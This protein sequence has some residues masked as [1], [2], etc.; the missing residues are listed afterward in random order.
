[1]VG[2]SN[3][4]L[5]LLFCLRLRSWDCARAKRMFADFPKVWVYLLI[6]H[7]WTEDARVEST[8]GPEL[9]NKGAVHTVHIARPF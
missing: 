2:R 9:L 1:M 8:V 4:P 5:M 7:S 3:T 6:W